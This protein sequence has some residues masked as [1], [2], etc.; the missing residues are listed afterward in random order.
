MLIKLLGS[1]YIVWDK[2]ATVYLK[3]AGRT[4][5]YVRFTHDTAELATIRGKITEQPKFDSVYCVDLTDADGVVHASIEKRIHIR[6]NALAVVV[7]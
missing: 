5:F 4:T 2:A 7:G 3:R 1:D 6:C